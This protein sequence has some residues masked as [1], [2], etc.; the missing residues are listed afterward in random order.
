MECT[1]PPPRSRTV[2]PR[3]DTAI[4][5][6]LPLT[7]TAVKFRLQNRYNT[8]NNAINNNNDGNTVQPE[9]LSQNHKPI[10]LKLSHIQNLSNSSPSKNIIHARKFQ[11]GTVAS[12]VLLGRNE[13][14]G[15][16]QPSVSRAL[17]DVSFS[18]KNEELVVFL[19]M[20]KA[21]GQHG[22]FLDGVKIAEPLGRGMPI[23]DGCIVSLWGQHEYA[24]LIQILKEDDTSSP[25]AA[26]AVP[27][28]TSTHESEQKQSTPHREIRKRSHQL[29]VGEQTCALCMDILIQTTISIPCGHHFCSPCTTSLHN[30]ICPSCRGTVQGWMPARSFDTII[31]ATALQGCFDREDAVAYLERRKDCGEDD[32]TEEERECILGKKGFHLPSPKKNEVVT[33]TVNAAVANNNLTVNTSRA[34]NNLGASADNAICLDSP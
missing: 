15:I 17:C 27:N 26:T 7:S 2:T 29:M 30:Q 16:K 8:N 20:R 1:A 4:L 13:I 3:D 6:L 25:V 31:W 32:P 28:E 10:H 24:Y 23:R 14:T 19:S 33:L 34:K 21:P 18:R 12:S 9:E 22:V 5:K 11:D